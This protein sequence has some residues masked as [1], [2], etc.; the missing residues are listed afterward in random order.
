MSK[1]TIVLAD[2]SYT[3]RRI[4]ELSFSEEENIEL[5]SFE[6]GQNLSE[7]LLELKPEIVLVDIKLPEITGYEVC[8]FINETEELK[9][10]RVFLMKGGFEPINEG[11]LFNLRY[12]DIITKPFDS[13]ALVSTIKKMLGE[14]PHR[15]PSSLPEDMPSLPPDFLPDI[16]A[17]RGPAKSMGFPD[18]EEDMDSDDILGSGMGQETIQY[19]EE[20]V[21]PSEEIT[22]GTQPDRDAL[23]PNSIED[24]ENPFKEEGPPASGRTGMPFHEDE[25]A[26]KKKPGFPGKDVRFDGAIQPDPEIQKFIEEQEKAMKEKEKAAWMSPP[27]AEKKTGT[28]TSEFFTPGRD[29]ADDDLFMVE[30]NAPLAD[31]REEDF[32]EIKIEDI[33]GPLE[34]E[35][36][37]A[38]LDDFGFERS[39]KSVPIP[40]IPVA[41][42]IPGKIPEA[43]RPAVAPV[44]YPELED[45]LGK[46]GIDFETEVAKDPGVM[47]PASQAMGSPDLFFE[48]TQQEIDVGIKSDWG[49]LDL[50]IPQTRPAPAGKPR[51]ADIPISGVVD[52]E[53]EKTPEPPRR[54]VE[55]PDGTK[56]IM[57]GKPPVTERPPV[58]EKPP[59]IERPPQVERRPGPEKMAVPDR[60]PVPGKSAVEDDRLKE[61]LVRRS[62]DKMEV[63]I[64]EMLWEILPPLAEKIIKEEIARL[65]I[66]AEK[67]IK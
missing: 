7:K 67:S 44:E 15:T 51:P 45:R 34:I 47:G 9:H 11:L 39:M 16:E 2:S 18:I 26:M 19:P 42:S 38:G 64:K 23:T 1:K 13:N 37:E 10:T 20:E 30:K 56:P 66:E 27:V 17:P 57:P 29:L 48:E 53:L 63:A 5:V 25:L 54:V 50:G 33:E 28:D 65:S 62:E 59:V 52:M 36:P 6:D 46:G 35:A 21:L 8:K 14:K 31:E 41:G 24:I 61:E 58:I 3:I 60:V 49:N 55:K 43:A 32:P 4:V 12:V 40:D 22:Q